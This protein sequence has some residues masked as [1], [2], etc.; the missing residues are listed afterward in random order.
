VEDMTFREFFETI[1]CKAKAW[2]DIL[3][4]AGFVP[5]GKHFPCEK[6]LDD[7][8]R[9][10][11]TPEKWPCLEIFY[12][13]QSVDPNYH[14][15][16]LMRRLS[17]FSIYEKG[18]KGAR[19]IRSALQNLSTPLEVLEFL[20]ESGANA[21][22]LRK[23]NALWVMLNHKQTFSK[24]SSPLDEAQAKKKQLRKIAL[25]LEYLNLFKK[26]NGADL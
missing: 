14:L 3:R 24:K 5:Q 7:Y 22:L 8:L 1:N 13:E 17:P 25:I 20:F 26:D 6:S 4:Q 11:R 2:G 10:Y 23:I 16:K 15:C 21:K 9:C 12:Y 19:L 18:E